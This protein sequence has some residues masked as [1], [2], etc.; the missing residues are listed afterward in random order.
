M[1][2]LIFL[3]IVVFSENPRSKRALV[4]VFSWFWC[5]SKITS[6]AGFAGFKPV[7]KGIKHGIHGVTL[8]QKQS[9]RQTTAINTS[10]FDSFVKKSR[11]HRNVDKTLKCR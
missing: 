5:F 4:F 11:K 7:Y 1:S 2:H 3:T 10:D 6:F 9:N 8:V